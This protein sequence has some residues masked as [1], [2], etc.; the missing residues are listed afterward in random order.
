[1]PSSMIHPLATS[2]SED[3]ATGGSEALATGSSEDMRSSL[4]CQ[5][6]KEVLEQMD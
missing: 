6:D 5:P 1:M 4:S 2:S 3:I